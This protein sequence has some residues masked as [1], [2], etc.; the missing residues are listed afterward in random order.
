[1]DLSGGRLGQRVKAKPGETDDCRSSVVGCGDE[2]TETEWGIRGTTN[3]VLLFEFPYGQSLQISLEFKVSADSEI[4]SQF[5]CQQEVVDLAGVAGGEVLHQ[6]PVLEAEQGH[7]PGL[8][9]PGPGH[10]DH[11]AVEVEAVDLPALHDHDIVHQLGPRAVKSR[12]NTIRN[13]KLLVSSQPSL[14]LSHRGGRRGLSAGQ[15]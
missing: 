3:C 8:L 4:H 13:V 5:V 15:S 9:E 14:T 1:M 10:G 6:G 11:A 7:H 12:E 2:S